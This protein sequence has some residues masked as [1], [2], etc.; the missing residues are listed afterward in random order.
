MKPIRGGLLAPGTVVSHFRIEGELSGGG[1]AVVYRAIDTRTGR[2][3]A[4]KS[5]R[6]GGDEPGADA[7]R[8]L[9]REVRLLARLI[10]PNIVAL[11]GAFESAGLPWL[12]MELV[13][14]PSL[15]GA[16]DAGGPLPPEELVR[17]GGGLAS[18]LGLAHARGI[19]HRD[20]APGNILLTP[21]GRAKLADF[22]LAAFDARPGRGPGLGASRPAIVGTPGYIAPEVLVGQA[23]DGRSD[24]FSLGAVLYEMGTGRP[25]FPG[26]TREA[27]EQ[28]T[29]RHD[30]EPM[31]GAE[32]S[33]PAALEGVIRRAMAKDPG[34][35][36]P[37]AAALEAA[38]RAG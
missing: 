28:A 19:L 2:A 32:S 13:E 3:A 12:A 35:R 29:L 23:P 1:M 18:A 33:F 10:H 30:P 17:Q 8:R 22:G 14:G 25:A 7:I 37:D 27:I 31:G 26:R 24:L 5:P 6:L 9:L 16:I 38:L 21:E 36:F 4:L 34:K 11:L 20:V 15:S